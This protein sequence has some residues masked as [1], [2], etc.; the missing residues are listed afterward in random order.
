MWDE[1]LARPSRSGRSARSRESG[2]RD[3]GSH[4]ITA[5]C[6]AGRRYEYA[7][8][9]RSGNDDAP[10]GASDWAATVPASLVVN[11]DHKQRPDKLLG[12]QYGALP[13]RSYSN[14][15]RT[16]QCPRCLEVGWAGQEWKL[17]MRIRFN[18]SSLRLCFPQI[19]RLDD[20]VEREMLIGVEGV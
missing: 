9:F 4:R 14:P 1:R 2:C 16:N 15:P 8:S 13:K 11:L 6:G 3:G 18:K 10:C 19:K 20:R 12:R 5:V 7:S 17:D